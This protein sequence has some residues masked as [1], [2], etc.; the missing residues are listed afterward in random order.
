MTAEKL[1]TYG[2]QAVIEGVMMRGARALAIAV[3]A[4]DQQIVLKTE[5]L[6]PIYRGRLSKLPFLRGLLGLWDAL[7]LGWKSLSFSANVAA[8][9]ATEG[10]PIKFEGP[11]AWG[12]LAVSLAF[13]ISLFFLA[14]AAVAHL[15]ES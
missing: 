2:G 7:G 13:G 5:P 3:R 1:P 14:P 4:P 11:I 8:S 9:D 6:N 12:T 15:G 10:E